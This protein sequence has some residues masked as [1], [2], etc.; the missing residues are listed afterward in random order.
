MTIPG[1]KPIALAAAAALLFTTV[2]EPWAH[3]NVWEQRKLASAA[4]SGGKPHP[5]ALGSPA[6]PLSAALQAGSA[7]A[8]VP[9]AKLNELLR[10]LRRD[11][12]LKAL[13]LSFT[14]VR[15][16]YF[17]GPRWD[18]L[19]VHIQDVHGNPEAQENIARS[20]AWLQ[21]QYG[22][23]S[24]DRRAPAQVLVGLEG[25]AGPF[26][27][28]VY[29]TFPDK[30]ILEE[31]AGAFFKRGLLT[32][33]EYA[34]LTAPAEPLL[35]GIEDRG[36]YVR[37][38]AALREGFPLEKTLNAGLD[39]METRLAPLKEKHYSPALKGWDAA[40]RAYRS[41]SGSLGSYL[42]LVGRG[43]NAGRYPQSARFLEALAAEE[44]L[45][46]NRA[47][48]ERR[49]L[50][51]S[52]A[53]RLGKSDLAELMDL[54]ATFRLG[55]TGYD[56]FHQALARFAAK[57]GLSLEAFP[58]FTRY[59]RYVANVEK[60]D[61]AAFLREFEEL[62]KTHVASLLRSASAP[63]RLVH[64]AAL[65]LS[66]ARRLA[67]HAFTPDDWKQYLER[68]QG[69]RALPRRLDELEGPSSSAEEKSFART[70]APFEEFYEAGIARN[71]ALVDNLLMKMGEFTPT[72]P[73]GPSS[74]GPRLAVLV[75]GGFHSDG[76]A[77]LLKKQRIAYVTLA[78]RF[79]KIEKTNA[80][81]VFRGGEVSLEKLFAGQKLSLQGDLGLQAAELPSAATD[82]ARTFQ[83]ALPGALVSR[84]SADG[85]PEHALRAFIGRLLASA[86]GAF[87]SIRHAP[88]QK[89][90]ARGTQ[91][92]IE[93]P[94]GLT[95]RRYWPARPEKGGEMRVEELSPS[96]WARARRWLTGVKERF[97][98]AVAH[99]AAEPSNH[100]VLFTIMMA[101]LDRVAPDGVRPEDVLNGRIL[102]IGLETNFGGNLAPRNIVSYLRE[103]KGVDVFGLDPNPE[104]A[105]HPFKERMKQ[106]VVEDM[107]FGDA[108]F[109]TVVSVGLFERDHV[110]SL[111]L[112][113]L[114]GGH[115][116]FYR[117][118]AEE[119]RRVLRPGGRFLVD[120]GLTSNREF[121]NTFLERGFEPFHLRG[122]NDDSGSFMLVKRDEPEGLKRP[123]NPPTRE[124]DSSHGFAQRLLRR[125][126]WK[127]PFPWVQKIT[128]APAI[129]RLRERFPKVRLRSEAPAP[130]VQRST[131]ILDNNLSLIGSWLSRSARP[132]FDSHD[133][134]RRL[135]ARLGVG[136]PS[137]RLQTTVAALGI[138]WWRESVQKLFHKQYVAAHDNAKPWH[139]P[140]R[141]LLAVVLSAAPLAL[142]LWAGFESVP[143]IPQGWPAPARVLL[144]TAA[145]LPLTHLALEPFLL[146]AR[147]P[148]AT[149]RPAVKS[150]LPEMAADLSRLV[151]E[152]RGAVD[153]ADKDSYV[154]AYA[155][156]MALAGPL[157]A[158]AR[159]ATD[160]EILRV[161]G[162][163][164]P[165]NPAE[166][167]AAADQARIFWTELGTE[168][169]TPERNELHRRI[170]KEVTDELF[171]EERERGRRYN[172]ILQD[173]HPPHLSRLL[174]EDWADDFDAKREIIAAKLSE[175]E[176]VIAGTWGAFDPAGE[177]LFMRSSIG[178]DLIV[179][180]TL[181]HELIHYL[182]FKKV[183][184]APFH[185]EVIPYAVDVLERVSHDPAGEA[186]LARPEVV[187]EYGDAGLQALY[188]AGKAM[189]RRGETGFEILPGRSGDQ[190]EY[191]S[192][193]YLL[194]K[195]REIYETEGLNADHLS[196]PDRWY[197][198][199]K[200]VGILLAGVLAGRREENPGRPV[201]RDLVKFF[202]ALHERYAPPDAED[203]EWL[204]VDPQTGEYKRRGLLREL[205]TD[206]SRRAGMMLEMTPHDRGLWRLEADP[207]R[208]SGRLHAQ[209]SDV[210][211]RPWDRA[212]PDERSRREAARAK[213]ETRAFG[214][215]FLAL[216]RDEYGG[217][218]W[219]K[220]SG[221]PLA[222]D[223]G[224]RALW[225]QLAIPRGLYIAF[226]ILKPKIRSGG[227]LENLSAHGRWISSVFADRYDVQNPEVA[228]ALLG[229]LPLH[230]Q[231][232]DSL[233]Y[234]WV[235]REE[236]D[237][238]AAPRD[239]RLVDPL[240]RQAV[241]RTFDGW[242]R[243][244][245]TPDS[246][247][248]DQNFYDLL[249]RDIWPEFQGLYEEAMRRERL[250][251][252]YER[253]L[254]EEIIQ[255]QAEKNEAFWEAMAQTYERLPQE[256]KD[257]IAQEAEKTMR[258]ALENYAQSSDASAGAG[259]NMPGQQSGQGQSVS[260][261]AHGSSSGQGTP[262][263]GQSMENLQDR[264]R[265][266]QNALNELEQGLGQ[267][268]RGLDQAQSAA[269]AAGQAAQGAPDAQ[270]TAS[271]QQAAG[272]LQGKARGLLEEARDLRS[273]AQET[274][275]QAQ[276]LREGLPSSE[277]GAGVSDSSKAL[278]G[279]TQALMDRLR[280]LQDQVNRLKRQADL[281]H[282]SAQAGAE[283][284]SITRQLDG[285]KETLQAVGDDIR[286]ARGA[287]RDVHRALQDLE[288]QAAQLERSLQNQ[289]A[290]PSQAPPLPA[291][292]ASS[293]GPA[294]AGDSPGSKSSAPAQPEELPSLPDAARGL[295]ALSEPLSSTVS[296]PPR[297]RRA[298]EP[299][300]TAADAAKLL[301]EEA[302]KLEQL[303]GLNADE[304]KE[305][306]DMRL[307]L[308]GLIE[309]MTEALHGLV[310]PTVGSDLERGLPRAPLLNDVVGALMGIGGWALRHP[311]EPLPVKISFVVD[312][313]GSMKGERLEAAQLT[314]L[315]LLEV[316]FNLNE[317]LES[318]GYQPIPFE[319]GFF[320]D[321]NKTYVTHE[322][323]KEPL[324]GHQKPRIIYNLLKE[325]H[326]E[327]G[328][329]YAESLDIYVRRLINAEDEGAE[330][331]ERI[332]FVLSDEDVGDGQ[333]DQVQ[334]TKEL[335]R[336]NG[337][338]LRFVPMGDER[339]LAKSL[340][341]HEEEEIILPRPLDA[342]PERTLESLKDWVEP[343]SN[344]Y[345]AKTPAMSPLFARFIYRP[346]LERG[347]HKTAAVLAGVLESAVA[348]TLGYFLPQA[349]W[350]GVA[351]NLGVQFVFFAALH[352]KGD[353]YRWSRTA[354]GRRVLVPVQ[355]V[356]LL[357]R[358]VRFG[359]LGVLFHGLLPAGSAF[360]G[361]ADPSWTLPFGVSAVLGIAAGHVPFNL[362]TR[363]LLAMARAVL[364]PGGTDVYGDSMPV[365]AR[366][367]LKR[368][369]R[370]RHFYTEERGGRSFLVFQRPTDQGVVEL[371]WERGPGGPQTPKTTV[372]D[373]NA[374]EA[375]L[376]RMMQAAYREGMSFTSGSPDGR[377]MLRPAAGRDLEIL[378]RDGT[379]QWTSAALFSSTDA[380]AERAGEGAEAYY[381]NR[382]GLRWRTDDSGGLS[383]SWNGD[384]SPVEAAAVENPAVLQ[385][386]SLDENRLVLRDG[387]R[388]LILERGRGSWSV[389]HVLSVEDYADPAQ[390]REGKF[391]HLT[392]EPGLG[393]GTMARALASL[394]NEP[395][396][397]VAGNEGLDP[398]DLDHYR[399][400]GLK[401]PFV[402]EH[403]PSD[404]A[405]VLHYGGI[406]FVDEVNKIKESTWQSLKGSL[407]NRT[408][409]WTRRTERGTRESQEPNHPRAR[410]FAASNEARSGIA[411]S[412]R[413]PD[414]AMQE[415]ERAVPFHWQ[416]PEE[417]VVLQRELALEY[418]REHGA[419]DPAG[420]A[421][422]REVFE[423]KLESDIRL[424]VKAA[425]D[426]RLLF[427]GYDGEQIQKIKADWRLLA[428]DSFAPANKPGLLY[429]RAPS[430]R[431]IQNILQ[432]FIRFP[433][434][435]EK[436]PWSIVQAYFSFQGHDD[437][438]NTWASVQ[439]DFADFAARETS[440]GFPLMGEGSLSLHGDV[441]RVQPLDEAGN[442]DS[443]WSPVEIRLHADAEAR[444]D[445]WPRA[446]E[447]FV[448]VPEN[449][450][451]FY[452]ALQFIALR[453]GVFFVGEQGA[454][455]STLT[456]LIQTY[457]SGPE[458]ETIAMKS[459]T[460][461]EQVAFEPHIGEGGVPGQ[462]GFTHKMLPRA[463][464]LGKIGAVEELNQAPPSV[465][466]LF[467][468]VAQQREMPVPAGGILR[469]EDGFGLIFDMNPFKPGFHVKNLSDELW[470]RYPLL[471][472]DPLPPQR[473][474]G[475]MA[476]AGGKKGL[477]VNPRVMGEP[478]REE[479]GAWR[480]LLGVEQAVR[481]RLREDPKAFP[482]APTLRVH[483]D[484]VRYI[485]DYWASDAA[486]NPERLPQE[487]LLDA[488]LAWFTRRGSPSE[489]ARWTNNFK[490]AFKEA[491][492]WNEEAVRNR[493]LSKDA[494]LSL[495]GGEGMLV[496][497]LP[498][499]R[500]PR[501]G[502]EEIDRLLRALQT[503]TIGNGV[504][505]QIRR[506]G[507]L[508]QDQKRDWDI[509]SFA[510]KMEQI[511]ILKEIH[512]V[513]GV[514]REKRGDPAKGPAHSGENLAAL[515]ELQTSIQTIILH[516]VQWPGEVLD[517]ESSREEFLAKSPFPPRDDVSALD[518]WAKA[519]HMEQ[520][521]GLLT[522]FSGLRGFVE[523]K[524]A[525]LTTFL[526]SLEI[527]PE[528]W[529]DRSGF[530]GFFR[531]FL[532]SVVPLL[533]Q[534]DLTPASELIEA[535]IAAQ[536]LR[537]L[538]TSSDRRRRELKER[539]AEL[540]RSR[541]ELLIRRAALMTE[542][543]SP[544]FL[545][546]PKVDELE[547]AARETADSLPPA[548]RFEIKKDAVNSLWLTHIGDDTSGSGERKESVIFLRRADDG[549]SQ[550]TFSVPDSSLAAVVTD[551]IRDVVVFAEGGSHAIAFILADDKKDEFVRS[552]PDLADVEWVRVL[553]ES[554]ASGRS[555]LRPRLHRPLQPPSL[556]PW[557]TV[558]FPDSLSRPES[559]AFDKN[560]L[561]WV[562]D[563]NQQKVHI[564]G[565]DTNSPLDVIGG[566][567]GTEGK[568][569][570]PVGVAIDPRGRAVIAN[571]G[572]HRIEIYDPSLP[573]DQR[574][575]T[576]G[577]AGIAA[578]RFNEPRGIAFDSQG[579]AWV[580]DTRDHRVQF[581]DLDADTWTHEG[582]RGSEPGQFEVPKAIAID[583]RDR[584]WVADVGN[585][586]LQVRDP[587][588][589]KWA[590][591]E[592]TA[593]P[594]GQL[595][596]YTG[597]AVDPY[598]RIW[599]T[600]S[601]QDFVHVYDPQHDVLF[602]NMFGGSGSEPGEF[603][604]PWNIAFDL[605]GNVWVVDIGNRRFQKARLLDARADSAEG[606]AARQELEAQ[607]TAVE[608]EIMSVTHQ[609]SRL[610]IRER[611]EA[612]LAKMKEERD[613]LAAHSEERSAVPAWNA[614]FPSRQTLTDDLVAAGAHKKNS[615]SDLGPSGAV[616]YFAADGDDLVISNRV[617][618]R[619][620]VW[621]KHEFS[622][623][624]DSS[625]AKLLGFQFKPGGSNGGSTFNDPNGP[626]DVTSIIQDFIITDD[627]KFTMVT[628]DGKQIPWDRDAYPYRRLKTVQALSKSQALNR[629]SIRKRLHHPPPAVVE[630]EDALREAVAFIEGGR[631]LPGNESIHVVPLLNINNHRIPG[632]ERGFGRIGLNF[633][634]EPGEFD[635]RELLKAFLET[636]SSDG[637]TPE[638]KDSIRGKVRELA[639]RAEAPVG[640]GLAGVARYL[641]G[642]LWGG[643]WMVGEYSYP[644]GGV[645]VGGYDRPE[646]FETQNTVW[647]VQGDEIWWR[648][649]PD[650][651]PAELA[652]ALNRLPKRQ[653]ALDSQGHAALDRLIEALEELGEAG[654]GD[655]GVVLPAA[656]AVPLRTLALP[657][658]EQLLREG[659][660]SA[661]RW[662][663]MTPGLSDAIE[664]T[665]T[666]Q[667]AGGAWISEKFIIQYDQDQL[668]GVKIRGKKKDEQNVIESFPS[669]QIPGPEVLDIVIGNFTTWIVVSDEYY[670]NE[671]SQG[672]KMETYS[673]L[674][675][676][677]VSQAWDRLGN[678]LHR[679]PQPAAALSLASSAVPGISGWLR[680]LGGD[681]L[682]D[683]DTVIDQPA[684]A[685][686]IFPDGRR[687]AAVDNEGRIRL[688]DVSTGDPL[689]A[690]GE[691]EG[692]GVGHPEGF[693]RL[694]IS[695]N[696]RFLILHTGA[697]KT[698]IYEMKDDQGR[699]RDAEDAFGDSVVRVGNRQALFSGDG[700]YLFMCDGISV[701]VYQ[702]KDAAGRYRDLKQVLQAAPLVD[703]K[704]DLGVIPN[705]IVAPSA[706]GRRLAVFS[707][708]ET[709][710]HLMV[711]YDISDP[712]KLFETILF[713]NSFLAQD[714]KDAKMSPDGR[715]LA[716]AAVEDGKGKLLVW[717]L[718]D[719]QG[720]EH[721]PGK[722]PFASVPFFGII[723]SL[724]FTAD[725]RVIG[726]T[727]GPPGTLMFCRMEDSAEGPVLLPVEAADTAR[728]FKD[729]S[730]SGDD[731]AM[732][733]SSEVSGLHIWTKPVEA[734]S[735][736][737]KALDYK[738]L[739]SQDAEIEA[740]EARLWRIDKRD[741]LEEELARLQAE[742][743][744]SGAADLA[745]P[746]RD[747]LLETAVEAGFEMEDGPQ[748][749]DAPYKASPLSSFI[750]MVALLGPDWSMNF[751]YQPDTLAT[752][753]GIEFFHEGAESYAWGSLA[754][755][756][757]RDI[758]V[759]KSAGIPSVV[760]IVA[761][762]D[763]AEQARMALHAEDSGVKARLVV[764]S[765][766]EALARI[767]ELAEQYR[768][769]SFGKG[770]RSAEQLEAEIA[771][772][773][774]HVRLL[775]EIEELEARLD[776]LKERR[777]GAVSQ[778]KPE[779]NDEMDQ[780]I[781]FVMRQR[782]WSYGGARLKVTIH[783]LSPE[784]F[785]REHRSSEHGHV[786][787]GGM[788]G[789][790]YEVTLVLDE[791]RFTRP[792][793]LFTLLVQLYGGD[794]DEGVVIRRKLGEFLAGLEPADPGFPPIQ[795]GEHNAGRVMTVA[796]GIVYVHS[797]E[798]APGQPARRWIRRYDL[799]VGKPLPPLEVWDDVTALAV[800][801]GVLYIATGGREILR[802]HLSAGR[803]LR[804]ISFA[805]ESS[806]GWRVGGLAVSDGVLYVS[807]GETNTIRRYNLKRNRR[808]PPLTADH[809][810][811]PRRL[812]LKRPGEIV[813]RDGILY[814]AG[815]FALN[816]GV[817]RY[818][819]KAGRAL[820][821][822]T[823]TDF[824]SGYQIHP[825]SLAASRGT[826]YIYDFQQHKAILEYGLLG[827]GTSLTPDMLGMTED[828][829]TA[830]KQIYVADGV[831]YM[832]Y[833]D[834]V[835]RHRLGYRPPGGSALESSDSQTA[836]EDPALAGQI[837]ALQSE[838]RSRLEEYEALSRPAE[839]SGAAPTL[840]PSGLLSPPTQRE[841]FEEAS[842]IIDDPAQTGW[843]SRP[844]HY[845]PRTLPR[846]DHAIHINYD[847]RHMDAQSVL[848]E[849]IVIAYDEAGPLEGITLYAGTPGSPLRYNLPSRFVADIGVL[850]SGKSFVVI[851]QVEKENFHAHDLEQ[852]QGG[853][854]SLTEFPAVEFFYESEALNN[855]QVRS[856]LHGLPMDETIAFIT[857]QRWPVERTIHESPKYEE[858]LVST[859]WPVTGAKAE[860]EA[861]Y[862]D[863][864][865][866]VTLTINP[867]KV[868]NPFQ[869]LKIFGQKIPL[870]RDDADGEADRLA[871]EL[872]ERMSQ[873]GGTWIDR[874]WYALDMAW[875]FE[876][877]PAVIGLAL[878][879]AGAP[880]LVWPLR[881]VLA[882][883]AGAA[884]G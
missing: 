262:D 390:E 566:E 820:D 757:I 204:G 845:K 821:P 203:L 154:Q 358:I 199:Q 7:S 361:M 47:E 791:R 703:Y 404:M 146:A 236:S 60:I 52:M 508:A 776:A 379:Q 441:L 590:V 631:W 576:R 591:V 800:Y 145:A 531:S 640:G 1:R 268:A 615:P 349:G 280:E 772:A 710:R 762:E 411:A 867:E 35:W 664:G 832:L 127:Q 15:D 233:L 217:E 13:P 600:D 418:A 665:Y 67:E 325:F 569:R 572:N 655:L 769:N 393:K 792:T 860:A 123:P 14:S 133:A 305:Y 756:P 836:S 193:D 827:R 21:E 510:E 445:K 225:G 320:S 516:D 293:Q 658:K 261:P 850:P 692:A 207:A 273:S 359:F 56:G 139:A 416:S 249:S 863:G 785:A 740:I 690:S 760:L 254:K 255:K 616:L 884:A 568:L 877:G 813:V 744:A 462:T 367:T 386:K 674:E 476:K 235:M 830:A 414:D 160:D 459:D 520:I 71:Q 433:A 59:V 870:A 231:Y 152:M 560:G 739:A 39:E 440:A 26:L 37:H 228:R 562:T 575:A 158:A 490:E 294:Q 540:G 799:K 331:A 178:D 27:T 4:L 437:R 181:K 82:A 479:D 32:G 318:E 370:Y 28:S 104:V 89:G 682:P 557:E 643:M 87:R 619:V 454:G 647:D 758:G 410:V 287:E 413:T 168:D 696:G 12:V 584:V 100:V 399:A 812:E 525:E 57:A 129:A 784:E 186:S 281:A 46:F 588:T 112:R 685:V 581:G 431:V 523:K 727:A 725:S 779:P 91:V 226:E 721:H 624:Y 751:T 2:S 580:V 334:A 678:Q 246:W 565:A 489:R 240:V 17:P 232:L 807:E 564:F 465:N 96:S 339:L 194:V 253:L 317:Q 140:V 432:H 192:L 162:P 419:Y 499:V 385:I 732:V 137:A 247:D 202:E 741:E 601:Q 222:D 212:G 787:M 332:L 244:L 528:S 20:I 64:S 242:S 879:A 656:T 128:A 688:F 238:D 666:E 614:V 394:M 804:S 381:G 558:P 546:L 509:L 73:G 260:S 354:D 486:L 230:L 673:H 606:A 679:A 210:F 300:F 150:E 816:K 747:R 144:A 765:E 159:E 585:R 704:A 841:L 527:S 216:Y 48:T 427:L 173:L 365:P 477:G 675:V 737:E 555:D 535:W 671:V 171:E 497:D 814:I 403:L 177:R 430:P 872:K 717:E 518:W 494:V 749:I 99:A 6:A 752:L 809:F 357:R 797:Y 153:R 438:N 573:E 125:L 824:G 65:D 428:D 593:M 151:G 174:R 627:G 251:R 846:T 84:A 163:A 636:Y 335:A 326:T 182:A 124:E 224:F 501:T 274:R 470:E 852:A 857:G 521:I 391:I 718:K 176:K 556:S 811:G 271:L 308:M 642:L 364:Q 303:Y 881:L 307:P 113:K 498:V 541:E 514:V 680:G 269:Q 472:F 724:N 398:E 826:I 592:K 873:G 736:A 106:G 778:A 314:V 745:P 348:M 524:T 512:Q 435:R 817:L 663:S 50:V 537:F 38:V 68:A 795:I 436:R 156:L 533:R 513:V 33:A 243:A 552:Y 284:G 714:V 288:A 313:S 618:I 352:A 650:M 705:P 423:E 684:K 292:T 782:D 595:S 723:D 86:K 36:L 810:R 267:V 794:G 561:Y 825:G 493:D 612:R 400:I 607:V 266:L 750:G 108:E 613:A 289:A 862:D 539:L 853:Y 342:L 276:G 735:I 76:L 883:M 730:F 677:P 319:V 711:L 155:E 482:R 481:R 698:H 184:K 375:Q 198:A 583:S 798:T 628:E 397:F 299:L 161:L 847:S 485:R 672:L 652:E 275:G 41:R 366:N 570:F 371:S 66:L 865:G 635:A 625:G 208:R 707:P 567:G 484:I 119:I 478:P 392:G 93:T 329:N 467:N 383:L 815:N 487:L 103:E 775:D 49:E 517:D 5:S 854:F 475:Y 310:V 316:L 356:N 577:M 646:N 8:A 62:E 589:G 839:P 19:V 630:G 43:L 135:L 734:P 634:F 708:R 205:E 78:P 553:S 363:G 40:S 701:R 355:N 183:L 333:R 304:W 278:D 169:F 637:L 264:I 131:S 713:Q 729:V 604:G 444:R 439:R 239:P 114:I 448:E 196:D 542:A 296:A 189:A 77:E 22:R 753:R 626:R 141:S 709:G 79:E 157:S 122:Q 689:G 377:Y 699:Y 843:E 780:A 496:Q 74:R 579:K 126:G 70:L 755:V 474:L 773:A 353:L 95:S 257:A 315:V 306:H 608:A 81:D 165:R 241:S 107:P 429:R 259:M 345:F 783:R 645:T 609:L 598:D 488:Y 660:S 844:Y 662:L 374:N 766:E 190:A 469:A 648:L 188:Q 522:L 25:A 442:P 221:R 748:Q 868:R 286:Q 380:P 602:F 443:R 90:S 341:E 639:A 102:N 822:I 426:E 405:R 880:D 670:Q 468:E 837:A 55:R 550:I 180:V 876:L 471:W 596:L 324:V 529:R 136:D 401:E 98:P 594:V 248:R 368:I 362:S 110:E 457:L 206:I 175:L 638:Q 58:E 453:G 455:K 715:F 693:Y 733:A 351:A 116:E 369:G 258:Q 466:A 571:S 790:N 213:A 495:L 716:A 309:D 3:S 823:A 138:A 18:R 321:D 582:E 547:K 464:G 252:I 623:K 218:R 172:Q 511:F 549:V 676:I 834:R 669:A 473:Q 388:F 819:L 777:A 506:L 746:T 42:R 622:L 80:L 859:Q 142:G 343:L 312:R 297:A 384:F 101:V 738:R 686:Q 875:W 347:Y 338:I 764:L 621:E 75:A 407:A 559:L 219:L 706:D 694:S 197:D 270:G 132:K 754:G 500:E 536:D 237:A 378:R 763:A 526:E 731:S 24:E 838:L 209:M 563:G 434:D 507:E 534:A 858:V 653:V 425:V 864:G 463:M 458:R 295:K 700:R 661:I 63:A 667:D 302:W 94:S 620:A 88:V 781:A 447:E 9:E 215:G 587:S 360:F 831:L 406:I 223:P 279:K 11:P 282:Q 211:P 691:H 115:G 327:G 420:P 34:G 83:T 200:T 786:S 424:L 851:R 767:G 722:A 214:H 551:F 712:A 195:A 818:D 29:R 147:V 861:H 695:S 835:F 502:V 869:L 382:E 456:E 504:A 842:R 143:L 451:L 770:P 256:V 109:D 234:R 774:E 641:D 449:A 586:R 31:V 668:K 373:T 346:L 874:P 72:D 45:D 118:A 97:A 759:T 761:T 450:L 170:V 51:E 544:S 408:H 30:K 633:F 855:P 53:G 148:M 396:Y 848:T 578:G 323:T 285:M 412:S 415:R 629:E 651:T 803:R 681:P 283:S 389:L 574:W 644:V 802:W 829:F 789:G 687:V 250:R 728:L 245:F 654:W 61:R 263:R 702:I 597:L 503:N 460:R 771:D 201:V 328:T 117:A 44:K 515:Q 657:P 69:V 659:Q 446:L 350:L 166:R 409:N 719:A 649:S 505:N 164:A 290:H 417:E 85:V 833:P 387:R 337:I 105:F 808:L 376:L 805:P 111:R 227:D 265:R 10:P 530:A 54:A 532:E 554:E 742:R 603:N 229:G 402:S 483:K 298:V 92:D 491:G 130:P 23:L 840:A 120:V 372:P 743:D 605:Q 301:A 828:A 336:Q 871:G 421:S 545:R 697:N 480:G 330:R 801:D 492:L 134:A 796:D 277:E 311:G 322:T 220:E 849:A 16:A 866:K 340:A 610:D 611:L 191:F 543:K 726:M 882:L 806:Q 185:W 422:D 149:G 683:A 395:F 291:P 878:W 632:N 344:A 187:E 768:F 179:R 272:D 788:S 720:R 599:I 793:D 538:E 519:F 548:N 617:Q 121:L 856:R 167:Q 452:R 461:K